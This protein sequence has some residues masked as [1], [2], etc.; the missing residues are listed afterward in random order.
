MEKVQYLEEK[1]D[2][3]G[4]NDLSLIISRHYEK[5][6]HYR[7]ALEFAYKAIEVK[8]KMRKLEGI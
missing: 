1:G 2:L 8:E 7:E 6:E 5:G 3:D 4:V